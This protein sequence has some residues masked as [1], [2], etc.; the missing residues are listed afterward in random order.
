MLE[1][2]NENEKVRQIR[3]AT[4]NSTHTHQNKNMYVEP[5]GDIVLVDIQSHSLKRCPEEV[6]SFDK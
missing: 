5:V 2:E 4:H 6:F 1:D 3:M